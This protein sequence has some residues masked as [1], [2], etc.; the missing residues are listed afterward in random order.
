MIRYL[1]LATCMFGLVWGC[2]STPSGQQTGNENDAEEQS[3]AVITRNELGNAAQSP[4]Q[5]LNL[6]RDEIPALLLEIKNPY[7][8]SR[9]INCRQIRSQVAD[10]DEL[11]GRDWDVAPEARRGLQERAVDG[12]STAFIDTV[13]SG[14][15]S[16]IPYRGV[17]RSLSGA[18]AYEKKLHKAYE[19]GSH[20][21][22]FLKGIGLMKNCQ[23]PAAPRP[24]LDAAQGS[25][26]VE[27]R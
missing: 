17:V 22:T 11:L 10:L 26:R 18:S 12:A 4:L 20:R 19:R 25:P 6:R 1:S 24:D 15:S 3:S 5:D 21:R 9:D 14:A 8:V 16:F 13:A 27:F 23:P 2:A 7:D